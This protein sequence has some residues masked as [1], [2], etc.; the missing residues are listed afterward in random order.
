MRLSESP[1]VSSEQTGTAVFDPGPIGRKSDGGVGHGLEEA[2]P[3]LAPLLNPGPETEPTLSESRPGTDAAPSNEYETPSSGARTRAEAPLLEDSAEAPP[4]RSDETDAP[5]RDTPAQRGPGSVDDR[6]DAR[7]DEPGENEEIAP[8]YGPETGDAPFDDG[9]PP[10]AAAESWFGDAT[11]EESLAGPVAALGFAMDADTE[12]SLREGLFDYSGPSTDCGEPQVWQGGLRAAIGALAEGYSTRLVFVD[13]DGI[14]YPAGAIHE[15]A[16]VCEVGTVVIAIGS[17]GTARPGRELLLAGVSDYLAKPVSAAMVRTAAARAAA[18][19][20]P[21][22]GRVAAFAGAGGSGTTTLLAAAALHAAARGCYVSVLD[23][24]RTV[25]A[26]AL[27]LDVEPA[28]GLDQLLD[29]AGGTSP[30]PEMIEGVCT[31]RSDRIEVYA[32]RWSPSLP[33]APQAAAI[34]ALLGALRQRSQLVLVDKQEEYAAGPTPRNSVDL[35]VFV[36]EP[37]GGRAADAARILELLGQQPPVLLVQN[38]ARAIRRRAA[39]GLLRKAGIGAEPDVEIPFEPYL[40]EAA[41]RGWPQDRVPR[42]L[43]TPLTVLIDRL[44]GAA[45]A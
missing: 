15:L 34:D 17:D 43:R 3:V 28:A 25:A 31:R 12:E 9:D 16:A 37:T 33:A 6:D 5:A 19:G 24:D 7:P 20:R 29:A 26:A 38:H 40:T 44:L 8:E 22:G 41:D 4:A 27:S 32:Y 14:P 2:G 1:S 21:A 35:R 30:D 11:Q 10:D 42:S 13:I 39:S 18:A 23:L 36:V 45:R